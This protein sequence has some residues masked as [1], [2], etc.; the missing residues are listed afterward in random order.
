MWLATMGDSFNNNVPAGIFSI[1]E[2]FAPSCKDFL[3]NNAM[4]LRL[5]STAE[6]GKVILAVFF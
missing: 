3:G 2:T 4:A 6:I 5:K 1:L